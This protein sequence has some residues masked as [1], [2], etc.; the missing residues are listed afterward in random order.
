MSYI[1]GAYYKYY[2]NGGESFAARLEI[3][4]EIEYYCDTCYGKFDNYM[5]SIL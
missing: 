2:S 5:A 3:D 4:G 1:N